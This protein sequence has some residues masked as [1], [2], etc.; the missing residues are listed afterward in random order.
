MK[1]FK[2]FETTKREYVT[3]T[4][5][6]NKENQE[7]KQ[8]LQKLANENTDL[9]KKFQN[10]VSKGNEMTSNIRQKQQKNQPQKHATKC[11]TEHTISVVEQVSSDNKMKESKPLILIA[12]DSIIKDINGWILSRTSRM[13]VHS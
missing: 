7:L 2:A 4:V 12:G 9:S 5:T 11:T 8:R 3:N 6:L 1:D 13:K 10:C